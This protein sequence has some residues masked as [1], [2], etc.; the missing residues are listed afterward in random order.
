[1]LTID[2]VNEHCR[3]FDMVNHLI[4]TVLLLVIAGVLGTMLYFQI[5]DAK[6]YR[7]MCAGVSTDIESVRHE[8]EGLRKDIQYLKYTA[9]SAD[10][11]D[12]LQRKVDNIFIILKR[13]YIDHTTQ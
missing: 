12:S 10:N 11:P 7:R 3:R 1:M 4:Q 8:V 6:Q 5:N 13:R 2:E 9:L